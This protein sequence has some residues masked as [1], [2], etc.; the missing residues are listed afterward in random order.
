MFPQPISRPS[1]SPHVIVR[2]A[3]E[4]LLN[5]QEVECGCRP[6]QCQ[7][8][9]IPAFVSLDEHK[10]ETAGVQDAYLED[11]LEIDLDEDGP[12]REEY[13]PRRRLN[14]KTRYTAEMYTRNNHVL[15]P[16]A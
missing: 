6:Q 11:V 8:P 13:L 16:P 4:M 7:C 15:P 14:S 9:P 1:T 12:L 5:T 10:K 3:I 2:Q